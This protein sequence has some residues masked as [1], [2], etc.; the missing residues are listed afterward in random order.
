MKYRTYEQALAK[1][2][3]SNQLLGYVV[4]QLGRF[5][6]GEDITIDFLSRE[7]IAAFCR[8]LG[9][10]ADRNWGAMQLPDI[11]PMQPEGVQVVPEKEAALV[12][13]ALKLLLQKDLIKPSADGTPKPTLLNDFLPSG[14]RFRRK[15]CLGHLW[16]FR[17]ALA[18]ELEHGITRS[19]NVT[20][21]H[22]LLTGM[23]VLAHVAED[24][25]YYARLWVMESEGELFNAQLTKAPR[26]QVLDTLSKLTL[27]RK[28]LEARISEKLDA[29]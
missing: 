4:D 25:L 28:H 24:S 17:Y 6:D 27:A 7:D 19:T 5:N 1:K 11:A 3:N 18:V 14:T 16:E 26:Q 2:A 15:K 20:N 21:N 9:F 29:A 23:V 12:L 8:A 13:S 22:P 10:G